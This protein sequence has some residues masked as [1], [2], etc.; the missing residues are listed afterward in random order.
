MTGRIPSLLALPGPLAVTMPALRRIAGPV[1]VL[2]V[3]QILA[4]TVFAGRHTV[5][6]PTSVLSRAIDDWSFV[7]PNLT[8]TF[9]EAAWGF[10]WG[11]LAAIVL[12]AVFIVVRPVE[13]I[14]FRPVV[15]FYCLPLVAVAPALSAALEQGQP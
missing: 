7:L 12:A 9:S 3:W 15:A 5:P 11:N 2:V 4:L 8:Q 10:V 6:T 14:F 13:R 1:A